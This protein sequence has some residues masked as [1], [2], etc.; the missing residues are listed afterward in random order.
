METAVK[1]AHSFINM[2]LGHHLP[3]TQ[4]VSFLELTL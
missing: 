4:L 3:V 2:E 1:D